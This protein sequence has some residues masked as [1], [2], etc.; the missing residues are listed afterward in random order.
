MHPVASPEAEQYREKVQAFL[1]EHLP[2]GWAGIGSLEGDDLLTFVNE[3]RVTLFEHHMLAPAWPAEYGGGGLSSTEQVVLAEEF[4]KA[5]VPT[6]GTNDAFCIGMIGNTIM[7]WGT[8]E[9]KAH[10]LP[11]ILSGEDVWCQGYSEPN[12]GSDLGNLGCKAELDGDEWIINGQKIWTSAGTNGPTGS[13][14]SAAPTPTPPS[15]RAS[16]SCSA[17]WTKPGVEVRPIEMLSGDSDF[18]EVFFTD[19]RC[20]KDNVV[21][22]VNGGWAV[23]MTLLGYERGEA[24]AAVPVMFRGGARPADR[25]GRGHRGKIDDPRDPPTPGLVPHQGRD[26]ALS[27][28]AER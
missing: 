13:S 22:E 16:P 18:N 23:A 12:A 7:Q 28:H 27:R 25:A 4:D 19:A 11:R 2:A 14:S 8:D 1:A 9:Q 15:T 24:A 5:G 26:H 21:G 3:W 17:R 10:F 20:D 6:G